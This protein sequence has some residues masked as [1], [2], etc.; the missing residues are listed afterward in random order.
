MNLR[1]MASLLIA[2]L[3]SA[4]SFAQDKGPH[5]NAIK[6]RQALMQVYG[7]N[8]GILG[9]MAKEKAPYDADAAK[10]AANNLFLAM[11]MDQSAM[12]PQG[13]DNE[14]AGNMKN[15][16]LAAIWTTYPKVAEAGKT[17]FAAAEELNAVAGDGLKAL[18]SA[19]GGVGK[20]CK[21]CHDDF[22]AKK[23]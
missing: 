10:A 19:M 6:G 18:Q 4:S 9:A 1:I 11:S 23:K 7:F 14:T 21:G 3:V 15:R 5:D 12:W 2:L 8:M 20:G 13:S 17:S 22:R 16:A